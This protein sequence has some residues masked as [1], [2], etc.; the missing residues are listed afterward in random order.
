MPIGL[1]DF[2]AGTDL[3]LGVKDLGGGKAHAGLPAVT[4]LGH[5]VDQAVDGACVHVVVGRRLRAVIQLRLGLVQRVEYGLFVVY[6]V[7]TENTGD[8]GIKID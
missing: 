8:G 6:I 2:D 7:Q 4:L 5:A 1:G 3:A